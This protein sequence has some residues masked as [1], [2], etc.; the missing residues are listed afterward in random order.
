MI[1]A[2]DTSLPSPA[3]ARLLATLHLRAVLPQMAI[4]AAEDPVLRAAAAGTT[5]LVLTFEVAG[6]GHTALRLHPDGHIQTLDTDAP[7][8]GTLRL[9]FPTVGQFL[10]TVEGRSAFVLPRGG[11]LRLRERSRLEQASRRFEAILRDPAVDAR[12]HALGSLAVGLAAAAT[13]LRT[14]P[15][16]PALQTELL[17]GT[18]TFTCP[19]LPHAFWFDARTLCSGTGTPPRPPI[20]ETHLDRLETLLA[21]LNHSQD[22]LAALGAGTLRVR[23]HLPV[24]ERFNLLLAEVAHLLL[25]APHA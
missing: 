8:P 20:A 17:D 16:G 12:L 1:N 10:R 9:W 2:R 7:P 25:P 5:E 3:S 24:M 11:L 14:H 13:W 22:S 6:I 15:A 18:F 21:E 4:L 19:D 23:G